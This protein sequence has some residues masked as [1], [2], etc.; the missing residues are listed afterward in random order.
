MR[1]D[2]KKENIKIEAWYPIGHG[3]K[4]LIDN[5]L[6]SKLA[7]KYNKTN[8]QIILRWHIQEGFIIFPRSTNPIHIKENIEIFDFNLSDE[9]MEEIRKLDKKKMYVNW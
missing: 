4:D 7:K 5:P 9:E 1:E 2:C 6:F 8:A 3:N